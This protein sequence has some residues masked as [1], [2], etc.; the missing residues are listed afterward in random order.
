VLSFPV[1]FQT[2]L[3]NQKRQFCYFCKRSAQWRSTL[4]EKMTSF[5]DLFLDRKGD[6]FAG[7]MQMFENLAAEA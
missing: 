1:I 5:Y 6:G 4:L 7:E 3:E 2:N